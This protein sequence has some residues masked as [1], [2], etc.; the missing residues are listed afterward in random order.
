MEARSQLRHRPTLQGGTI[1]YFRSRRA[2]SQTAVAG[3]KLPVVDAT[4]FWR[5]IMSI[6][7]ADVRPI[8]DA[9]SISRGIRSVMMNFALTVLGALLTGVYMEAARGQAHSNFAPYGFAPYGAA[10]WGAITIVWGLR[11]Y[12]GVKRLASGDLAS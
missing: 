11:A 8:N 5:R 9:K 4:L 3:W 10:M 1:I 12:R 2:D 6:L 7:T